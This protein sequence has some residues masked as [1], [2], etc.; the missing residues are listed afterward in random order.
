M[1]AQTNFTSAESVEQILN[2][3]TTTGIT[4]LLYP[5]KKDKQKLPE[6]PEI[7]TLEQLEKIEEKEPFDDWSDMDDKIKLEREVLV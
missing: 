1:K 5:A 4:Y 2:K 6:I 3:E 7:P